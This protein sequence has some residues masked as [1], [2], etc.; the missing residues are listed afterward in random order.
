M[1][2]VY[3]FHTSMFFHSALDVARHARDSQAAVAV[4]VGSL[5][6]NTDVQKA[7]Q[8]GH[9]GSQNHASEASSLTMCTV[10][11][12]SP[13]QDFRAELERDMRIAFTSRPKRIPSKYHY[14][15]VGSN[16]FEEITE[17]PEYYLTRAEA[18]I[19]EKRAKD[20]MKLVV[21]DELVELGSGSSTKTRLLIEAMH[22]TGGNRY[23]PIDISE[24]ALRQAAET[25]STDY[26]WLEV[27][28]N[29]GDYH[30]DLPLL[31]R[32]G[33]RLLA[34]L[35]SSLGNYTGKVRRDILAQM[36]MALA[37]G[38]ALL[39][40]VD[41]VKDVET[42]VRAYNDATGVTARFNFNVLEMI[43]RELD[44]NFLVQEFKHVPSWNPEIS[45]IESWLRAQRDMTVT[46]RALNLEISLVAG[47]GIM[48]EMSCK[49]TQEGITR[50]LVAAG[51]K[52]VAW[53][54][55]SAK[56][57]GLLVACR[58]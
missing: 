2:I 56:Q 21:P 31:Q 53:Y 38:D 13:P 23:A 42:L 18:E 52:M 10:Y 46:L 36:S 58:A 49:F 17:L 35:G 48:T 37:P 4:L 33:R 47:E 20:I 54:T 9:C 25:L 40:G 45:G 24:S 51:L 27:D 6:A 14:D 11:R 41:L 43:N 8:D 28:G 26:K 50:E 44:A 32:K 29:V 3:T 39:M 34:F 12:L 7:S 30:T 1:Y 22:S 19:L 5:V 15:K 16:L 55:D 57:F